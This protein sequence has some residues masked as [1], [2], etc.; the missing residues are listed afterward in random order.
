MILLSPV[1]IEIDANRTASLPAA[2][3]FTREIDFFDSIGQQETS[4]RFQFRVH[5]RREYWR[6]QRDRLRKPARPGEFV[7]KDIIASADF[8]R[9]RLPSNEPSSSPKF[10][11]PD[12]SRFRS[13]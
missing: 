1:R 7:I 13:Q 4:Q 8:D 2:G 10:S 5:S 3:N 12:G 9:P 11:T 6:W